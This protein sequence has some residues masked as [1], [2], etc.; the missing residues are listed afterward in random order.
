M[1]IRIVNDEGA[2]V[3]LSTCIRYTNLF[4]CNRLLGR[5]PLPGSDGRCGPDDGP[6]CRSCL[7][8]QTTPL[9]DNTA[10]IAELRA[11]CQSYNKNEAKLSNEI[12][13]LQTELGL[14][15]KRIRELNAAA[16][17][18]DEWTRQCDKVWPRLYQAVAKHFHPDKT[19]GNKDQD[20]FVDFFKGASDKNDFF[21]GKG[22][23]SSDERAREEAEAVTREERDK[24]AREERE[25]AQRGSKRQKLPM[26]QE[27]R[28]LL[29]QWGLESEEHW[30]LENGVFALYD[31]Q[32]LEKDD[33]RGR[34]IRLPYFF[35][36]MKDRERM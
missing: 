32:F 34:D 4:Y 30:L 36:A 28:T 10:A 17:V 3:A 7:R 2:E 13:E 11:Q 5:A 25:E 18:G 20:K 1:Y 9:P 19:V 15:K 27:L 8:F 29:G 6:Q 14:K 12:L 23:Q 22:R 16:E 26:T 24:L 21:N 33:M 35:A 31:L